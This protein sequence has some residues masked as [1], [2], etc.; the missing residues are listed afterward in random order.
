MITETGC[1]L[2]AGAGKFPVVHH[3]N[4]NSTNACQVRQLTVF[5]MVDLGAQKG[6][7]NSISVSQARGFKASPRPELP[8]SQFSHSRDTTLPICVAEVSNTAT[9]RER[10]V[11]SARDL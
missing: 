7:G 3:F 10:S 11:V 4:W 5:T 1:C 9:T 8:E 6:E 2:I